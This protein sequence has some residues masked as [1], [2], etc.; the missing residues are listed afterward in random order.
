MTRRDLAY[1]AVG[2]ASFLLL[3]ALGLAGV[4]LEGSYQ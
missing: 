1:A 3:I 2:V 4:A